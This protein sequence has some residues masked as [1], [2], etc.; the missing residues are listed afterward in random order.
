MISVAVL[1]KQMDVID[2]SLQSATPVRPNSLL[3]LQGTLILETSR[4]L[5]IPDCQSRAPWTGVTTGY[6][7]L[8]ISE[9]GMVRTGSMKS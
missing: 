2:G 6:A 8:R 1:H 9:A 7:E 3:W 4:D 5:V